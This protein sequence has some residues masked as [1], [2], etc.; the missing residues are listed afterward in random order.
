MRQ[1]SKRYCRPSGQPASWATWFTFTPKVKDLESS[2]LL[3]RSMR[4]PTSTRMTLTSLLDSFASMRILTN[5]L[6]EIRCH[7]MMYQLRFRS[8]SDRT[9]WCI[10]EVRR[11]W[12]SD[13]RNDSVNTLGT[14]GPP[15]VSAA[16]SG[17]LLLTIGALATTTFNT[18]WCVGRRN[19]VF[20]LT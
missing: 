4:T 13:W 9:S 5:W 14:D 8:G 18:V 2:H 16:F 19:G 3:L 12:G 1:F 17:S 11:I 15:S 7:G 6:R 10:E 20:S